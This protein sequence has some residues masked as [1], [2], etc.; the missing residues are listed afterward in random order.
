MQLF[1][2]TDSN[3]RYYTY[4]FYLR[5]IFGKKGV[6]ISL[7]AGM[8]CPN[9][10]GNCGYGG[11]T[12]CSYLGKHKPEPFEMQYNRQIESQKNKW[13]H[14]SV[15]I[16]Y[17][18]TGSNTYCSLDEL[19]DV[20]DKALGLP[21]AVG[22]IIATRAD[23]LDEEK[24]NYLKELSKKHFLSVELGMQTVHE[25][26]IKLI[27]R[28]YTHEKF[29]EGYRLL[30]GL[31]V[32]LHIINGLPGEN[33]EMMLETIRQT[34]S[35]KPAGVKIHLLHIL[36]NTP[37]AQL[38]SDGKLRIL[39]LDEYTDIVIKQLRLLPP[40]I[41]IARLTGDGLP[42]EL[43]APLWSLK[44]FTVINRIDVKMAKNDFW[45]GDLY[46]KDG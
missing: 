13:K 38:Y 35:L 6:R 25:D 5:R 7:D 3:K 15:Y 14:E 41:V 37:L 45:Q 23:C 46:S 24:A 1:E 34:T 26:T 20:C 27:N 4:D 8:G 39:S 11:C 30:E 43:I 44:K 10:D 12:F 28:G 33:E 29:L 16:P 42:D 2:N 22:L 18:Q 21:D 32:F 17:L 40:D 36:K 19:K 31:N 9:R